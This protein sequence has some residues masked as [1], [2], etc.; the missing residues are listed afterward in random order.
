MTLRPNDQLVSSVDAMIS[1]IRE[2]T[3]AG[4]IVEDRISGA[5]IPASTVE[6]MPAACIVVQ[7][8]GS[9]SR[10]GAR[11]RVE[12]TAARLDVICYGRTDYE[13]ERLGISVHHGLR[14]FAGDRQEAGAILVRSIVHTG[15][16]QQIEDP[17][18]GWPSIIYTYEILHADYRVG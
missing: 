8:N 9:P 1:A 11:D 2:H 10:P 17:Q 12:W 14:Q 3:N 15:G 13:A 16:P 4:E 7:R 5:K 6:L 18:T